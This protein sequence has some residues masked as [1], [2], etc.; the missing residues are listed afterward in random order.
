MLHRRLVGVHCAIGSHLVK[1]VGK[2]NVPILGREVNPDHQVDL[3]PIAQVIHERWPEIHFLRFQHNFATALAWLI[4]E[5]ESVFVL[6]E[7]IE[8]TRFEEPHVLVVLALVMDIPALDPEHLLLVPA[9][10][11]Q[12]RNLERLPL[13][14]QVILDHLCLVHQ[15]EIVPDLLEE[16]Q[17]WVAL[18]E[19]PV[20]VHK[21][22][23]L[24]LEID[25]FVRFRLLIDLNNQLPGD[26]FFRSQQVHFSSL[27]LT[28][29]YIC[30]RNCRH[31]DAFIRRTR[32]GVLIPDLELQ[33][34]VQLEDV[35]EEESLLPLRA[36][37]VLLDLRSTQELLLLPLECVEH[38]AAGVAF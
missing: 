18:A 9:A 14:V 10:Q 32:R 13:R 34:L 25:E 3:F 2:R 37:I 4:I 17:E 28:A 26:L 27:V 16:L 8:Q 1:R 20:S 31:A 5:V 11:L 21:I 33:L 35:V 22:D 30:H 36:E 15:E 29:N 7:N 19:I 38:L 23:S 12:C 24:P 6:V